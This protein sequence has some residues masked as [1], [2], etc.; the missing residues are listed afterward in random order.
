MKILPEK[1]LEE[2]SRK[3]SGIPSVI[4]RYRWDKNPHLFAAECDW[5]PGSGEIIVF[6]NGNEI[7]LYK[8]S[9]LKQRSYLLHELGHYFNTARSNGAKEYE[10]QMWSI[11]K[12]YYSGMIATL[13]FYQPKQSITLFVKALNPMQLLEVFK[14]GREQAKK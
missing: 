8:E 14:Y 4:V 3:V 2:W 13:V 5:V 9:E 1:E 12:T 11:K 10:A 7:V 6:M